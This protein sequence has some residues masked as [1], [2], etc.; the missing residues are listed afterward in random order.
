MIDHVMLHILRTVL[1]YCIAAFAIRLMGKR[2]IGKLSVFDLVISIMLAEIAV[3]AIEDVERPLYEGIVPIITLI[4]LQ[5]CL[6]LLGLKSRWFRLAADGKPVILVSDGKLQRDEMKRQRYNLDDLMLQ[7][8]EQNVDNVDDLQFAILETTGKLS[9]IPKE[10]R[11]DEKPK[12]PQESLYSHMSEAAEEQ[13]SINLTNIR[14]EALP[15]PLIMDGKVQDAN[16]DMIQKNR[17]WLKNQIQEH[18]I[19]DFKDVFLC[20]IDHKG[21]IYVNAKKDSSKK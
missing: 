14:Y 13:K 3:F 1:M 16:L 19:K 17:F 6:A 9:I 2:E 4:I 15:L 21:Q 10:K 11:P 5:V 8:R 18:G 20:S 7:L 12:H